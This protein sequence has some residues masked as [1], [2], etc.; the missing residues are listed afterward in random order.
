MC[1]LNLEI[2]CT[3]EIRI[4][5]L[6]FSEILALAFGAKGSRNWFRRH[7]VDPMPLLKAKGLI[8]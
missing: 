2:R 3:L 4:P 1:Q 7:L 6:H 5:T 8:Q